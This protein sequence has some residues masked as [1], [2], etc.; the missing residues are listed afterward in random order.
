MQDSEGG[1]KLG[2]VLPTGVCVGQSIKLRGEEHGVWV[3]RG[4]AQS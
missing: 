4:V 3:K 2:A 1:S